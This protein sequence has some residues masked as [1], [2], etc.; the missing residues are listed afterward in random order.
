MRLLKYA[1]IEMPS[2]VTQSG[3]DML[4][5]GVDVGG[6]HARAAA[7]DEAGSVV[8]QRR[9]QTDRLSD[10]PSLVTWIA[11]S[12]RGLDRRVRGGHGAPVA[13]GLALPGLV[14]RGRG[15]L[16]R[17]L[18]L[19][20]LEGRP[21][22]DDLSR[23]AGCK[24]L[25]FTDAEAAT[26]GEYVHWAPPASRFVHLRLGTGVACASVIDGHLVDHDTRRRTH[27]DALVV[28]KTDGAIP[29][30][31]GLR[32]C[33]ETI[34]SGNAL[35]QQARQ[36]GFG[37]LVD[38]QRANDRGD[39]AATLVIQQAAD[40]L[41]S[42]IANLAGRCHYDVITVGGGVIEL[43][44]SLAAGAAADWK[45]M[46]VDEVGAGARCPI[47]RARLGDQAGVIGAALLARFKPQEAS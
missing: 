4:A 13:V 9:A 14:D 16:V 25:L 35:E 5:I 24:P 27:M 28:D 32:G 37:S 36:Q 3:P 29:C 46:H 30:R 40:A 2:H 18:N 45:S 44:P 33:L 7:V 41:S 43:L 38:L 12:I 19:Q 42:A 39:E 21:I 11:D 47:E 26:W 6:T 22:Q 15:L 17:S 20:F 23:A 31:C 34:A 1:L 10:Y 8:A